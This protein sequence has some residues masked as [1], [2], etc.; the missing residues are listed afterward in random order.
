MDRNNWLSI[1]KQLIVALALVWLSAPAAA[2]PVN[3]EKGFGRLAGTVLDTEGNPLMGATI[4]VMGPMAPGVNE[5][6]SSVERL[7]TN[8][9]GEFSAGHLL[10]GWYSLRISAPTVH[11][12]AAPLLGRA[13][14]TLRR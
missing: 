6:E 13:T 14:C 9:R 4:L 8:F 2:A 10:P 7:V 5:A 12:R 11:G 1:R 3:P